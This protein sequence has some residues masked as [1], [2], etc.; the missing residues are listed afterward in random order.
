MKRIAVYCGASDGYNPAYVAAADAFGRTM[1]QRGIGLV[2]GGGGTGLMG[3]VGRGVLAAGGEVIGVI[4]RAL[5]ALELA[6][7][8]ATEMIVVDTMHERK[9]KMIELSDGFVVLPGGIGTMEELFEVWTWNSLKFIDYPLGL[10]NT[11]GY[12]DQLIAFA[13]HQVEEGF[14]KQTAFDLV[15]VSAEPNE[16]VDMM[17]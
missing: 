2:Y 10:L 9:A 12:Y 15:K 16:L 8:E 1:A 4:P 7:E 6:L 11:A 14:V 5:Y 17:F 3:A 13:A